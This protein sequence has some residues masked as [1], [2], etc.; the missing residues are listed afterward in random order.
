MAPQTSAISSSP[1][2][3][4]Q[5]SK[6]S[7]LA[8]VDPSPIRRSSGSTPGGVISRSGCW[9]RSGGVTSCDR[10][11][12]AGGGRLRENCGWRGGSFGAEN[13]G[14]FSRGIGRE[15]S[16]GGG[17]GVGGSRG[18]GRE[19]FSTCQALIDPSSTRRSS[20]ALCA[21]GRD[22][23][24][25]NGGLESSAGGSSF[26]RSSRL[27]NGELSSV[28]GEFK[29]SLTRSRSESAESSVEEGSKGKRARRE[30]GAVPSV[31]KKVKKRHTVSF[32][33]GDPVPEEEAKKRWPWR[34]EKERECRKSRLEPESV[35]V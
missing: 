7:H 8:L 9:G 31:H 18:V 29:E 19:R 30:P 20:A 4:R 1:A 17:G 6:L 11:A 15:R 27:S 2:S 23:G 25:R 14:R 32:F 5:K 24:P 12:V 35:T 3:R 33:V 13:L 26:R 22:G 34:F 16:D 10:S 21:D 28:R